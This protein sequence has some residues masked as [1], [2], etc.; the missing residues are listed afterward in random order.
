MVQGM[1]MVLTAQLKT[2]SWPCR[3]LPGVQYKVNLE[4]ILRRRGEGVWGRANFQ[5]TGIPV[6]LV[7][8]P[9]APYHSS[10][11]LFV[12]RTPFLYGMVLFL[13]GPSV[14]MTKFNTSDVH[15]VGENC[16]EFVADME[17][18]YRHT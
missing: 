8:T 5:S 14:S 4:D 17:G 10:G 2:V 13:G 16:L 9:P 18:P 7:L 15:L 1:P 6:K 12:K 3:T 11:V